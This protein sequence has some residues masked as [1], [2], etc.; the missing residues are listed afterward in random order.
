[1][2]GSR[3]MLQRVLAPSHADITLQQ[4]I[5]E[6]HYFTTRLWND[7]SYLLL[8]CKLF[9]TNNEMIIRQLLHGFELG[10][11]NSNKQP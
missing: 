2:V 9:L 1:M 10:D 4:T 6:Q 7:R 3:G 8:V 11:I 5:A